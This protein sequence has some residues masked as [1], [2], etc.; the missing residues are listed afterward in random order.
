MR[1]LR[2]YSLQLKE[3]IVQLCATIIRV[4]IYLMSRMSCGKALQQT[5]L[6][7]SLIHYLINN[8]SIYLAQLLYPLRSVRYGKG[9]VQCHHDLMAV[10]NLSYTM[11]ACRAAT[12]R[13]PAACGLPAQCVSCTTSDNQLICLRFTRALCIYLS[14]VRHLTIS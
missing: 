11:A 13:R 7:Y 6:I 8:G 1:L 4:L 10:A 2:T 5:A 12:T 3:F 14:L 9:T